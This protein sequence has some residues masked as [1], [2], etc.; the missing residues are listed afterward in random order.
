LKQGF[1]E[2][3]VRLR[4][5]LIFAVFSLL[6]A[7]CGTSQVSSVGVSTGE[8]IPVRS[9]AMMPGGGLLAD[10]VAVELS[11]RGFTIVDSAATTNLMVRLNMNEL[12]VSQP[13]GLAKLRGQGIDAVLMV[14]AA[15]SYDG[16]PQSASARMTSTN[17]GRLIAGTTWQNGFGG[18]A[19]SIADR[20]MRQG[21]SQAANQ[22]A[23]EITA[24]IKS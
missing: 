17:D 20:V 19:G 8:K 1:R 12:E 15:G 14:R 2:D 21:L 3:V 5:A 7:G 9:I 16:Q 10:A 6:L 4:N 13:Q 24:R 11:N 23:N 22:I 18:Q